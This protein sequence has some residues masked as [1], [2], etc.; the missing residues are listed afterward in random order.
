MPRMFPKM[1]R[2]NILNKIDTHVR[3]DII[4]PPISEP[5]TPKIC[6]LEYSRKPEWEYLFAPATYSF[7]SLYLVFHCDLGD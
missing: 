1:S 4:T 6:A 7:C 2:G 3:S 5:R